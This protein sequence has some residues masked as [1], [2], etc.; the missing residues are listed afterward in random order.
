MK[1]G[2]LNET[3]KFLSAAIL[4]SPNNWRH[5]ERSALSDVE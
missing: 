1:R 3:I 2:N 4:Y 5:N